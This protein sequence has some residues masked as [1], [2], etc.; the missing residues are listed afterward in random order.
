MKEDFL[1]YV[2]KHQLFATKDL[3]TTDDKELTILNS[4]KHNLY[5]GPDFLEAKIEIDSIIW[6]GTVE[7]HLKSS[8]WYFHQHEC[9]ANYKNVILHVVW[10]D[11][12]SVFNECNQQIPT[13]V[14]KGLIPKSLLENYYRLYS[15]TE[16]WIPCQ[17]LISKISDFTM[18]HW[19]MRLYLQRLETKSNR[20]NKLLKELEYDYEA[21]LFR[22][23]AKNFGL[24]INGEAFL[25]LA[26]QIDFKILR[27]EQHKFQS[28]NALLFGVAG[29]LDDA[30][31]D[32]YYISLQKEYAY[33]QHKYQLKSYPNNQFQFFKMR[34]SNF[35]TL[36]IAQLAALYH[37]YQ[38]LFSKLIACTEVLEFYSLFTVS[39]HL[40]WETH[41]TFAKVSPK[42]KKRI[43]KDFVDLVLINTVIPLK[44][45]YYKNINKEINESFFDVLKELK[46]EK[47]GVISKFS[48]LQIPIDSA[49]DSQ[50]LLE[51]K[52]SYCNQKLCL[53]CAIGNE[54]LK[55]NNN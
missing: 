9:D 40:F 44:F 22:L 21:V 19:K 7:M 45:T 25:N 26:K 47:N 49:F 2:W 51:L 36:R 30:I 55:N 5:T 1:H 37:K 14:L 10:E 13:L 46:A 35:P 18:Q 54:L 27:K 31:E 15:K 50:A 20:I 43:T 16:R 53:Q 28:L 4:G 52:N 23:L 3:K 41:F 6:S 42:R 48:D 8:D 38:N 12:V 29:F 17:N 24:N 33:L 11:D 34:P 39:L 32:D